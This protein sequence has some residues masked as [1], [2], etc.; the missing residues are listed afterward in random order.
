MAALDSGATANL[1]CFRWPEHHNRLLE[2][3]GMQRVYVYQSKAR[4]CFGDGRVGAVRRAADILVGVAGNTGKFTA[5][6]LDAGIPAL[7]RRGAMEALGGRL[8]L[9]RDL[10]VL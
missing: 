10:L 9:L 6:V 4:F 2:R 8:D 3:R 7:L 5:F 1:V